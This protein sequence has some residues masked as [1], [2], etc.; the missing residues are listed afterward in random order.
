MMLEKL[1]IED[2]KQVYDLIELSFPQDEY[3]SYENQR[4]LLND[5]SYS[6][7]VLYSSHKEVMAFIASWEFEHFI[8]IEHFALNPRHRGSGIGT[9][10][11]EEFVNNAKSVVCLEVEMPENEMAHRRIKFYERNGFYL[12][13]F[14]YHQP[15]LD[16]GKD[17]IPLRIMSFG[18][19]L[20][21]IQFEHVQS[22]L[23]RVVYQVK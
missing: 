13:D 14:P 7:S 9:Q 4:A 6:I 17:N 20:S 11:L 22:T 1:K 3:R 2:F 19:L 16:F 10:L 15:S 5:E 23:Y 21:L 8:Y 18:A 12:N